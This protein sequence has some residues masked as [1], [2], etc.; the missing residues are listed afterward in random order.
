M[1]LKQAA[2]NNLDGIITNDDRI[3]CPRLVCHMVEQLCPHAA[4]A[5]LSTFKQR[6]LQIQSLYM[7]YSCVVS[8]NS[9]WLNIQDKRS[10]FESLQA[11]SIANLSGYELSSMFDDFN[12]LSVN[13][14][15]FSK[16]ASIST[17]DTSEERPYDIDA[18]TD[19]LV[20]SL[21][22][23]FS[24][25]DIIKFSST[26]IQSLNVPSVYQVIEDMDPSTVSLQLKDITMTVITHAIEKF[27]YGVVSSETNE[28]KSRYMIDN[29]L[30]HYANGVLGWM[31]SCNKVTRSI[32]QTSFIANIE[33][34][35]LSTEHAKNQESLMKEI[36]T[37]IISTIF[38]Y[39][40][41]S[42]YEYE[43]SKWI[44]VTEEYVKFKVSQ[45]RDSIFGILGNRITLGDYGYSTRV[46]NSG[47]CM[48]EA[49]QAFIEE[50]S[51]RTTIT[52]PYIITL[53]NLSINVETLKVVF[54]LYCDHAVTSSSKN[55]LCISKE[56]P[57]Y[58]AHRRYLYQLFPHKE[59]RQFFCN[60][61]IRSLEDGN[62]RL[63]FIIHGNPGGS[64][65]VFFN[66][67]KSGLE[68]FVGTVRSKCISAGPESDINSGIRNVAKCRI[69]IIEDGNATYVYDGGFAKRIAG[70]DYIHLRLMKTNEFEIKPSGTLFWIH[71]Q[72]PVFD[73]LDDALIERICVIN[74]ENIWIKEG[75]F[76]ILAE[77]RRDCLVRVNDNFDKVGYLAI[78]TGKLENNISKKHVWKYKRNEKFVNYL[79]EKP[80]TIVKIMIDE[81]KDYKLPSLPPQRIR[82]AKLK[83]LVQYRGIYEWFTRN[84]QPVQTAMAPNLSSS[85]SAFMKSMMS[86]SI[87]PVM[88]QPNN[89][90]SRLETVADRYILEHTNIK[91]TTRFKV[92]K[93]TV[94]AVLQEI[95]KSRIIYINGIKYIK[96]FQFLAQSIPS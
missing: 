68:S 53:G 22:D 36:L 26:Y 83:F 49:V 74:F 57:Y 81:I 11:H 33:A 95:L 38:H 55:I 31:Y 21:R 66:F 76:N 43:D 63:A 89:V 13:L 48:K 12:D 24:R 19:K 9:I 80:G 92:D 16:S 65:S 29:N 37:T 69:A 72:Y 59:D 39:K 7:I 87:V 45:Y 79:K 17:E 47:R 84:Y 46:L 91:S 62:R 30:I 25:S 51:R 15:E 14:G 78:N 93:D 20:N 35:I 96:G 4:A 23:I 3:T 73:R 2:S 71:N 8:I 88:K 40:V 6:E 52:H 32:L 67:L 1:D 34:F 10:K 82:D 64:K 41:D 70:S 58:K 44:R 77:T 50:E 60:C 56:D 85:N 54:P 94:I 42:W 75:M 86:T 61:I 90:I 27:A 28:I 5:A 18:E